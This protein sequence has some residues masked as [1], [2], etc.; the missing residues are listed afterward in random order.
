[1]LP[2]EMK[3]P[4]S[5]SGDY[6]RLANKL[7]ESCKAYIE[8]DRD[9]T[10]IRVVGKTPAHVQAAIRDI[11]DAI[12]GLRTKEATGHQH[13]LVQPP[14]TPTCADGVVILH[15]SESSKRGTRPRFQASG[16]DLA[17]PILGYTSSAHE[18]R[19][20]QLFGETMSTLQAMGCNL[21]MSANFG[22]LRIRQQRR[23]PTE[24]DLRR[25]I[26]ISDTLPS[27]APTRLDTRYHC[28]IDHP[29]ASG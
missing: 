22:F 2:G 26:A 23:A 10:F 20:V 28:M 8:Y 18:D 6:S 9:D 27:R 19:I 17:A 21:K 12:R 5:M 1:M 7:R 16:R 4:I 15:F 24:Y 29:W 13:L 25:F 14:S 11:N 3:M